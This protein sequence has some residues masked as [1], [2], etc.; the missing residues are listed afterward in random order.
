M[1]CDVQRDSETELEKRHRRV[2]PESRSGESCVVSR[3]GRRHPST[4]KLHSPI[5]T[6]VSR[7]TQKPT[8]QSELPV[9]YVSSHS[10]EEKPHTV[11]AER[12]AIL[13]S[14]MTV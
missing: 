11:A 7:H 8:S 14:S 6:S 2:T 4:E 10:Y 3:S 5:R 12:H 1:Q 9:V 13:Q